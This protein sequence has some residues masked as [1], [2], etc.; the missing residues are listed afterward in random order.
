MGRRGRA[1]FVCCCE[2]SGFGFAVAVEGF[3][4]FARAVNILE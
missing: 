1:G 4:R 2:N 3:V